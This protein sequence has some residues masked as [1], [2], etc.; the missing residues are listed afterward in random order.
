MPPPFGQRRAQ[1]TP[2]PSATLGGSSTTFA[3]GGGC[4]FGA[5]QPTISADTDSDHRRPGV[6]ATPYYID[7]GSAG[8][9]DQYCI[10]Y[11]S[12]KATTSQPYTAT[13]L[14]TTG[15]TVDPPTEP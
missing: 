2:V 9:A 10:D 13:H 5:V 15:A 14:T 4:Q 8:A 12:G 7:G 3:I 6:V 11:T 1:P